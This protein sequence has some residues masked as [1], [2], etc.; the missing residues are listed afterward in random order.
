MKIL[1]KKLLNYSLE[2]DTYFYGIK[3]N[4]KDYHI[5]IIDSIALAR[6]ACK[7]DDNINNFMSEEKIIGGIIYNICYGKGSSIEQVIERNK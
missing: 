2:I 5:G 7:M 3:I 1:Q 4:I 6:M